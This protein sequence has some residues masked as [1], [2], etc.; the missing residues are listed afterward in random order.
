MCM[1]ITVHL[2][3][4]LLRG[5]GEAGAELILIK[6]EC[7]VNKAV[8]KLNMLAGLAGNAGDRVLCRG[9]GGGQSSHNADA[10]AEANRLA[11]HLLVNADDGNADI[12]GG[13]LRAVGNLADGGAQVEHRVN[14]LFGAF[15]TRLVELRPRAVS[16][17]ELAALLEKGAPRLLARWTRD[18]LFLDMRTLP[19][20]LDLVV[21]EI[22][23]KLDLPREENAAAK[24]NNV[25]S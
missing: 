4:Y 9:Q 11:A 25:P 13:V 3:D 21:A 7:A 2:V 19:P 14:A 15:P 16:P 18:S 23:E 24:N 5:A 20:E 10:G 22:F 6:A 1:A 12:A 17:A 8:D